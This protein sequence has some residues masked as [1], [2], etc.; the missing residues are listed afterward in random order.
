MSEKTNKSRAYISLRRLHLYA[1]GNHRLGSNPN[2]CF[3]W[4]PQKKDHELAA[5]RESGAYIYLGRAVSTEEF[6]EAYN[7]IWEEFARI[8]EGISIHL[9]E[10]DP[11]V[12]ASAID[13]ARAAPRKRAARVAKCHGCKRLRQVVANIDGKPTCKQCTANLDEQAGRQERS[14]EEVG[15]HPT[16]HDAD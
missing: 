9:I 10:G 12:P 13:P 1:N 11:A 5:I 7:D 6:N 16:G 14:V 3:W 15:V 4:V 8:Y 2:R